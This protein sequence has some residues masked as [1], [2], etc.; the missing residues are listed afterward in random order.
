MKNENRVKTKEDIC[1]VTYPFVDSVGPVLL[2]NFLDII[3]PLS[4]NLI[5]ITGKFSSKK[6]KKANL[7]N[8]RN[9]NNDDQSLIRVIKYIIINV[10]VTYKL[11]LHKKNFRTTIFYVGTS[12]YVFPMLLSKI[13]RKKIIIIVTGLSSFIERDTSKRLIKCTFK[14]LERICFNLSDLIVTHSESS[15]DQ[16]N[17]N[18]YSSKLDCHGALYVDTNLFQ[19]ILG[20]ERTEIGFIGRLSEEKGIINYIRA[21]PIILKKRADVKFLIAGEGALSDQIVNFLNEK[22][23]AYNYRF[24]GMVP[25]SDLPLY[26]NEL[27]LLIIPSYTET[28]PQIAIESMSCGTPVLSTLV[29]IIPELIEDG[30][31]GFL[32]HDNDPE[33]IAEIVL[34]IIDY[35]NLYEIGNR[36]I[37]F[38]KQRYGLE[39]A[40]DRYDK[41]LNRVLI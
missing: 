30:I 19:P 9:D 40:I 37:K 39:E 3:G 7:I 4:N 33:T 27:K 1:I 8:I 22:V 24:V 29:G 14:L 18:R 32:M 21:I 17:L 38:I 10:K 2:S 12:T 13:L 26:L 35:P 15:V 31:N 5:V 23:P 28:G 25:H 34:R 11:F 16:L 41:I 6:W 36:S 20:F